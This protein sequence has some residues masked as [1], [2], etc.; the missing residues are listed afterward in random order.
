MVTDCEQPGADEEGALG[1]PR[2]L[3]V[4]TPTMSSAANSNRSS[5]FSD[6][7]CR[8]TAAASQQAE[9]D[10]GGQIMERMTES[11]R[12]QWLRHGRPSSQ[13]HAIW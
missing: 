9:D 13:G 3:N 10:G 12:R 4:E 11:R 1:I 7:P 2:H 5:T 8:S 6:H